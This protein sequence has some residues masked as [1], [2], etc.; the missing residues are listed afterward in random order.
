MKEKP[1]NKPKRKLE[2]AFGKSTP[3]MNVYDNFVK[4]LSESKAKRAKSEAKP[5]YLNKKSE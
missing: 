2:T 5:A 3:D 1:D 4:Q